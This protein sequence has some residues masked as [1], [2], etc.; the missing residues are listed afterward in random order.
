MD[1][2]TPPPVQTCQMRQYIGF[3]TVE[4]I[5]Q[6]LGQLAPSGGAVATKAR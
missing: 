5:P 3:Q 6:A 1:T 4:A 2:Y